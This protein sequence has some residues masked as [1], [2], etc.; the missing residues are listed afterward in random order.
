MNTK[1]QQIPVGARGHLDFME[2]LL[3]ERILKNL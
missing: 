2:K 1:I 3:Y